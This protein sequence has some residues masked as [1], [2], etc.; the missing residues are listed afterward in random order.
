MKKEINEEF[1]DI[2]DS[3]KKKKRPIR[4]LFFILVLIIIITI[5]YARYVG[6]TG[7]II[8]EYPVNDKNITEGYD[9]FK[10][11]HF[12]DF[13]Y[14]RTTGMEELKNLVKEIN[15]TKPDIVVFTGDFIDKDVKISDQELSKIIEQLQKIN[16][17]YGNYYVNGNHD[18]KFDKFYEMFD[19]A[20]F[21]NLNDKYDV[22]YNKSNE[23]IFLSGL[24]TS[25]KTDFL[26]S[27]LENSNY[28]YKINIMHYPDYFDNIKKYD[29]NLVLAGH[30]HNGQVRLPFYGA[31][32]TPLYAKNYYKPYYKINNTN[33]YVSSGI[34]T[35]S[36]DFR[37]FNR[38]SFNLYRLNS[39]K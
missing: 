38:P 3:K 5:I 25:K 15:L 17:I 4:K 39:I 21:I 33:F 29:F 18:L 26:D 35:S 16:S 11:V 1:L 7:L 31:V 6:T 32:V 28:D 13:H 20:N 2:E 14:G 8:K 12:S 10:I 36:Y 27:A 19:T 34:G 9:G 24:S 37:L 30:S 23:T 22:I